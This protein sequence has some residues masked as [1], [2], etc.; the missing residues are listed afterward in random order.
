MDNVYIHPNGLAGNYQR[1]SGPEYEVLRNKIIKL[2][3]ELEDE[4]GKKPI[5]SVTKWEDV[6]KFL[7]LPMDRVGD[8][9]IANEAGYGWNEEMTEDLEVFDIPLKTGYKQAIHPNEEKSMWTPFIIMGPGVKKGYEIKEPKKHVDQYPTIMR[10]L[11]IEI[12]DFVEGKALEQI[13][14]MPE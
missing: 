7:D 3:I 11:G 10:L 2:L 13:F 1:A 6:E 8:L 4:N 9:V 5:A 12:P 14:D